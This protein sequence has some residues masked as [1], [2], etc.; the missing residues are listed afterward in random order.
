MVKQR[1]SLIFAVFLAFP[2][3]VSADYFAEFAVGADRGKFDT[4]GFLNPHAVTE[5]ASQ[6]NANRVA[7]GGPTTF[8]NASSGNHIVLNGVDDRD[9]DYISYQATV[10]AEVFNNV[11]LRASYKNFGEF[12]TSGIATFYGDDY[13]QV[14]I[15]EPQI[16][17]LGAAYR[18]ALAKKTYLEPYFEVGIAD[19]D[20]RGTQGA[21]NAFPEK[22]HTNT[23]YTLG[24]SIAHNLS[25]SIALVGSVYHTDLGEVD[26]GVTGDP[27]PTN[28]RPGEQ[29]QS[30]LKLQGLALGLRYN[31]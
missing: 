23:A 28:M 17:M 29:L 2:G 4:L 3:Y 19:I 27:P 14:L 24:V 15:A 7:A 26:T 21:S 9:S 31:F 8:S 5:K 25:D 13:Q 22:S 16:F 6:A 18:I 10:G 20:A 11:L 12:R 1:F 30:D